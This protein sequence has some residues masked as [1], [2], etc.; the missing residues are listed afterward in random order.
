M[1]YTG[2]LVAIV[3]VLALVSSSVFAMPTEQNMVAREEVQ[4]IDER[5]TANMI[6]KVRREGLLYWPETYHNSSDLL[7]FRQVRF[8]GQNCPKKLILSLERPTIAFGAY[9][10][11]RTVALK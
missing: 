7:L 1:I 9:I 11:G 10:L 4:E 3:A 5:N 2:S 6:V 8:W